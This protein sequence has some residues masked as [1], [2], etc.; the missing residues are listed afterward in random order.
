M[1]EAVEAQETGDTGG[2]EPGV[3]GTEDIGGTDPG[4]YEPRVAGGIESRI[5]GKGNRELEP[6][7]ATC[8]RETNGLGTTDLCTGDI[9]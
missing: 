1:W 9:Q 3:W 6:R 4:A 7:Q 2:T 5:R 8:G